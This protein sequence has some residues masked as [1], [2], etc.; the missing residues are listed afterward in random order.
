MNLETDTWDIINSYFRD[1]PNY[2]VRH[3]IDSYNDFIQNKIPQI[4]QNLAQNPPFI[5]ID[6]TDNTIIYEIKVYYGGKN[7][8]KYSFTKPTIKNFPSGEIRQLYPNEARLKDMTY[9]ADF[10]YSIDIEMTMKKNG[11]IVN[12]YDKVLI[13]H[14]PYLD[15]IYL[16]NIPIMLK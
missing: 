8:N 10:F 11:E 1:T 3:H 6:N 16:G 14:A 2:L 7:S 5:L 13:E 12:G 4:F 15:N 9:G